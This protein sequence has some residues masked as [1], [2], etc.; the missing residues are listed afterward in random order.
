MGQTNI[1]DT[2]KPTNFVNTEEQ[3]QLW[4]ELLGYVE[5]FDQEKVMDLLGDI[6]Q[7]AFQAGWEECNKYKI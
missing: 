5:E 4:I 2:M 3:T 7:K 6:S 1:K